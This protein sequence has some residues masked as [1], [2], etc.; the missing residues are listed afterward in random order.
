[1]KKLLIILLCLS[2]FLLSARVV[3]C[4]KIQAGWVTVPIPAEGITLAQIDYPCAFS[5]TP[6]LVVSPAQNQG[7]LWITQFDAMSL[8]GETGSIVVKGEA[9]ATV[10]LSWLA[11][12]ETP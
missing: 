11:T 6:V 1:M 9:G 10:R 5:E 8:T 2:P 7:S 4:P 3:A 12:L